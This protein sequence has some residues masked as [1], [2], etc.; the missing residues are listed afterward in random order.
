MTGDSQGCYR[1]PAVVQRAYDFLKWLLPTVKKF[2]RCYQ[3]ALG[4]RVEN[5]GLGLLGR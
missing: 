1:P 4:E 5:A 2:P 3:R